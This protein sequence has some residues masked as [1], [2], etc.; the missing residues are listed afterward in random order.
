MEKLQS[1]KCDALSI[2]SQAQTNESKSQKESL[3]LIFKLI[4]FNLIFVFEPFFFKIS[5][6]QIL[7]C[8]GGGEC[9]KGVEEY[10]AV[11]IFGADQV[12]SLPTVKVVTLIPSTESA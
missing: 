4:K 11:P 6:S 5:C 8:V 1:N 2:N 12:L 10:T 7:F 3:V 9:E